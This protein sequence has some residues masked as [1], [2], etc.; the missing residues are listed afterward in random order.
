M[1]RVAAITVILTLSVPA[2]ADD[3]QDVTAALKKASEARQKQLP[4][5][6]RQIMQKLASTKDARER[7]RLS[8]ELSALQELQKKFEAGEKF[9]VPD[10][11][12]PPE[13]GDWIGKVKADGGE[14]TVGAD[15]PR[16]QFLLLWQK[17]GAT[18]QSAVVYK[19]R[20]DQKF[21]PGQKITLSGVF[22]V[23]GKNGTGQWRVQEVPQAML[24]KAKEE[25]NA[26]AAPE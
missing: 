24:D 4:G 9:Y 15:L 11:G 8:K 22:R 2:A 14:L 16:G 18:K 6:I 17:T 12:L 3:Q 1:H 13:D 23:V 7:E 25:L 19:P 21:T 26:A 10:V 20:S 5:E